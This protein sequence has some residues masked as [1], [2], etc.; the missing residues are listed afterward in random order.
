ML[1]MDKNGV[2]NLLDGLLA[3]KNSNLVRSHSPCAPEG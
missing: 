1:D 2:V 3:A